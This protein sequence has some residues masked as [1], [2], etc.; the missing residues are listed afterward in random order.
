[1]TTQDIRY[2]SN[3]SENKTYDPSKELNSRLFL[4]AI[5]RFRAIPKL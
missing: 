5:L 3:W 2:Y 1:M 4:A